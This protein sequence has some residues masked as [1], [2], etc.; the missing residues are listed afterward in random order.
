M[1][2]KCKPV[3]K[4]EAGGN[5]HSKSKGK[6]IFARQT[7]PEQPKFE[8]KTK[9]LGGHVFNVG[10]TNQAQLFANVMEEIA[11]YVHRTMKEFQDIQNAI[12]NLTNASL[13]MPAKSTTYNSASNDII[14]KHLLDAHVKRQT[15][16]AK[17]KHLSTL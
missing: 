5:D 2:N 7:T 14:F 8:G 4:Q 13:T 16:N 6:R 3:V 17:I 9:D 1:A 12:K 10:F 11:E 15:C